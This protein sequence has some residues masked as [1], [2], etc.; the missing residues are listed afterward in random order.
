M[1]SYRLHRY[2]FIKSLIDSDLAG[3]ETADNLVKSPPSDHANIR[4]KGQ[5]N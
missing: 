3:V 1:Q 2:G 4:G 5:F